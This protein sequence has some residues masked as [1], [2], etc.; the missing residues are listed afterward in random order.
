M[1]R[2]L[3]HGLIGRKAACRSS[4]L[5]TSSTRVCYFRMLDRKRQP[6]VCSSY[7]V[8]KFGN[9]LRVIIIKIANLD[10]ITALYESKYMHCCYVG[11]LILLL[12]DIV[13]LLPLIV[14]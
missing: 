11:Y 6:P 7:L 2:T 5:E 13:D 8:P 14:K 12:S 9:S 4:N 3:S 10:Q 1:H